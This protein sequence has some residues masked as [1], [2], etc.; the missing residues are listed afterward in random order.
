MIPQTARVGAYHIR[1]NTP[2]NPQGRFHCQLFVTP[3][4]QIRRNWGIKFA[5]WTVFVDDA[6]YKSAHVMYVGL[7]NP[8]WQ[9][10]SCFEKLFWIYRAM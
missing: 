1:P 10:F 9:I 4:L 6:D 2:T 5:I 8:A 7:Q 3:D